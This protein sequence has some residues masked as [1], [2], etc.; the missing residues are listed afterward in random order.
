MEATRANMDYALK[1]FLF[2]L[3][4]SEN[5]EQ[6]YREI[7]NDLSVKERLLLIQM[8]RRKGEWYEVARP[9]RIAI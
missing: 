9:E 2:L 1:Q 7:R 6:V 8:T 5:K 3:T 4:F